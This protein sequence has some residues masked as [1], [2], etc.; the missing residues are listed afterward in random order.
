MYISL[1]LCLVYNEL[2]VIDI[3]NVQLIVRNVATKIYVFSAKN[4]N[5]RTYY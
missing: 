1:Y 2:N 3:S 4:H 5:S